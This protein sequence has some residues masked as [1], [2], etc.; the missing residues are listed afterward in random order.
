MI[1]LLGLLCIGVNIATL[2]YY[3][4]DLGPCPN[5]VYYTFAFGLFAY[6]SLDAIDGKQARRT[7]AS[8]PL[9][10]L[11]DHG[12]DAINTSLGVMTWASATYL[13][14]SWWT[15]ASLVASLGNFYLSTWEEYHTGI[16]YLGH[17]SGP[18]EGVLMLVGVQL[19][20]GYFGPAVWTLRLEEVA[21]L[22]QWS[23]S[24]H[25]RLIGSLQLNHILILIGSLVLV[26][27]IVTGLINV[28]SVKLHPTDYSRVDD[29]S[30]IKAMLGLVPFISMCYITYQ[31]MCLWP[32]LVNE[33]LALFIPVLGLLFGFQVGL[34]IL[35]HVAKLP[36]PYANVPVLGFLSLGYLYA[37][38]ETMGYL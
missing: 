4:S 34:M 19:V 23:Y 36:F 35:A 6:Q 26:L 32:D 14:Q 25:T 30:I 5:W 7:G 29:G 31:W 15:V 21:P 16:L 38:L 13:G 10:E 17:F 1:T 27:N 2:F 12:C 37:Y 3:S 22:L 20:S 11:F 8:G 24:A 18:V 33:H 9:G 28:I